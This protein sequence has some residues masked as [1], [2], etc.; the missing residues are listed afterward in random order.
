MSSKELLTTI[1]MIRSN[2][3]SRLDFSKYKS[4]SVDFNTSPKFYGGPARSNLIFTIY[5]NVSKPGMLGYDLK[6]ASYDNFQ[7]FKVPDRGENYDEELRK[8]NSRINNI[9]SGLADGIL[10]KYL[11]L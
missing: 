1:E 7:L 10:E 11:I 2:L 9:V 4:I 3:E 5:H 6:I 8:E